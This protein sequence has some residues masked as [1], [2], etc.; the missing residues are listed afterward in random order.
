MAVFKFGKPAYIRIETE[1]GLTARVDVYAARRMLE[2]AD[3]Q[4]DYDS[5]W[6]YIE[7]WLLEQLKASNT[8][9]LSG[10][11]IAQNILIEFNDS[12]CA[13]VIHLNKE[14]QSK[15]DGMLSSQQ[16]IQASP[17]TTENGQ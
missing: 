2:L 15:I 16:P 11:K 8:K 5:K 4:P 10:Y 13:L 7:T 9:D 6:Q 14:R 3:K 12:I 1:D 17:V